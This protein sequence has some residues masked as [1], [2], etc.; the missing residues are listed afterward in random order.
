MKYSFVYPLVFIAYLS[1]AYA[2]FDAAQIQRQQ[3]RQAEQEKRLIPNPQVKLDGPPMAANSP[4][5]E[6]ETPC[7]PLNPDYALGIYYLRQ[8]FDSV[9]FLDCKRHHPNG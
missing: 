7:F 8:C 4:I 5:P 6:N 2:D 1:P 3:Q 9:R